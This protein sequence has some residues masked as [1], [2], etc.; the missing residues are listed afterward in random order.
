MKVSS[1]HKRKRANKEITDPQ[2]DK[3]L[4]STKATKSKKIKSVI[5]NHGLS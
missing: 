3:S 1:I 4:E 2:K 5:I